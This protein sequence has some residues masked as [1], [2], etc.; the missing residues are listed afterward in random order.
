MKKKK[1]VCLADGYASEEYRSEEHRRIVSGYR[2]PAMF[3]RFIFILFCLSL[4]ITVVAGRCF[5]NTATAGHWNV[6][7]AFYTGISAK[8]HLSMVINCCTCACA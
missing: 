6:A 8:N 1:E 4:K 7:N 3:H 2:T 5:A